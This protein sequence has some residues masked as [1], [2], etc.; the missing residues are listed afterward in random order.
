MT[1]ALAQLLV[2]QLRWDPGHGFAYLEEMIGDALE[3]GVGGF[4]IS[5]GTRAEVLAL[6]QELH[7]RSR[8]PLLIAA[9]VEG[10]AASAFADATAL[11]PL[12]ALGALR[13]SEA[14]RRAAKLTARELRALGVNWAL[15]PVGDLDRAPE[16]PQL[17][18]RSFG[19]DAQRVAEW[20]VEWVDACQSEGVLACVR[21]YPGMGRATA[22][23]LLAP[24]TIDADAGTLWADDLLPFRGAADTGVASIM[25]AS[26]A[27]PRLDATGRAAARSRP[28]L[29][30]LLRGELAFSGLIV[31]DLLSSPGLLR[32]DDEG[33]AA[34]EMVGAGCDLLLAPTDLEG[35]LELLERAAAAGMLP[36][37]ALEA[38]FAR[39]RFWAD[40]GTPG[41]GREPTLDDVL[42]AR[43]VSDTVVHAVRGVFANVGPV[44]DVIQVDDDEATRWPRPARTHLLDALRALGQV[45]RLVDGPTAEGEGAVLLAL[46]GGPGPMKG[47]AGYSEGTRR[48]VARIVADARQAQRS[49]VVA[50]FAPPRLAGEIP[51]AA[52]VICGWNAERGMQEAM[53]RRLG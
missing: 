35:V 14:I 9:E 52:N 39:R 21:H 18:A 6:T 28:M 27:Y 19:S 24:A 42:W 17:G 49:V 26:V 33:I 41:P 31:S 11:P 47:R 53:A 16:H 13:D 50:M 36:A 51:E 8:H 48:R 30:E 3:V 37:D 1:R 40:L 44:I 5:G 22:D 10:G 23:P 25:A 4:V 38:S 12:A 43:K 34:I 2:P 29:T 45:P 20:V 7:R 32:G 46:Y 15:A